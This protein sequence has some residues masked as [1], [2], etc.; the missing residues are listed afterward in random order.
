[1]KTPDGIEEIIS[2][3][4][5]SPEEDFLGYSPNEMEYLLYDALGENSPVQFL[6]DIDDRTLNKMPLFRIVEAYIKI[7]QREKQIKL[8]PLGALPR[9]V[10]TELYDLRFLL[11]D[12]IEIGLYK[13]WKEEDCISIRS[14]RLTAELA[15]LV[16][17][18]NGKLSLTK[19]A[20]KLLETNNRQQ[21]FQF[22]FK[23]FVNKFPWSYNDG[24]PE[25]PVGQFGWAFSVI[26]LGKFGNEVQTGKFYADLYGKAFPNLYTFFQDDSSNEDRQFNRCYSIR[27]FNRFMLWFGFITME[28]KEI[29][30]TCNEPIQSTYILSSVF[31]IT[32]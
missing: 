10:I 21:L 23:A 19:V 15:G 22:F 17:K 14:A 6:D 4:N 25:V 8:T 27:T 28:K 11:D 30:S 5:S 16:R 32:S 20:I 24:Y 13:L 2:S 7:I 12:F 31:K 1:M 3:R 29:I 9:K 18:T 26:L